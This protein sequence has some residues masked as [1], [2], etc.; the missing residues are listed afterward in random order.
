MCH[1]T[2]EAANVLAEFNDVIATGHVEAGQLAAHEF[3]E[4][5]LKFNLQALHLVH[6][7]AELVS[8]HD[9]VRELID[10]PF[11]LGHPLLKLHAGIDGFVFC[12][13]LPLHTC[14]CERAFYSV[15]R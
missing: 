3:T 4:L 8:S 6:G 9:S 14:S 1:A 7:L 15:Q 12:H 10:S 13:N 5:F 11:P 2:V